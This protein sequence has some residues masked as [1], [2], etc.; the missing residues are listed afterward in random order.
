M[1]LERTQYAQSSLNVAYVL[2]GDPNLSQEEAEEALQALQPTDLA[3]WINVWQV[4]ATTAKHSGDIVLVK[5]ANA[6]SFDLPLAKLRLGLRVDT[7]YDP[8]SHT[9]EVT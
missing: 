4:H 9:P 7:Q 8:F 3:S 2:V 5:G 1:M 6:S